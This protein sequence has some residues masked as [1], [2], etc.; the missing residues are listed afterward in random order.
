MTKLDRYPPVEYLLEQKKESEFLDFKQ[1]WHTN[2][3]ELMKDIVCFANTVHDRD[4]YL[5]FG[6]DDDCNVVGMKKTRKKQVDVINSI[7]N[8]HFAGGNYPKVAVDTVTVKGI[9]IDILTIYNTDKTPVYL[10]KNYGQML[11]GCVYTRIGDM[12]TP[13]NGNADLS[14]IEMLWKKR[15]GL[16]KTPLEYIY[17]RLE[18]KLEWKEYQD[19]YYN[20]YKPEY[21]LVKGSS[22][23]IQNAEKEYY[24]FAMPDNS[25]EYA[26]LVFKYRETV[27]DEFQLV[28]LDGGRYTTSIPLWSVLRQNSRERKQE[29]YYQ[30]FTAD[31]VDYR[32]NR[33][34]YNFENFSEK[35]THD[36]LFQVIVLY[37]SA[38][39]KE[40]FEAYVGHNFERFVQ[41]VAMSEEYSQADIPLETGIV[42]EIVKRLNTGIVLNRLLTEYRENEK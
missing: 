31:S 25:V 36:L 21:C 41:M 2:I 42:P 34:L 37:R 5:I 10:E 15:L 39:E 29:Y 1:E 8:C 9:E 18:N 19:R 14:D 11:K 28:T 23:Q 38:T 22:L 24:A 12:N 40:K 33:L 17:D 30:Y 26:S 32:I 20:I 13:N 35:V 6:I 3:K 7:S 16:T 4:C 27:L